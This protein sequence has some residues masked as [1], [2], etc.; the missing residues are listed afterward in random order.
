VLRSISLFAIA[1]FGCVGLVAASPPESQPQDVVSTER[2]VERIPQVRV[3]PAVPQTFSNEMGDLNILWPLLIPHYR[4]LHGSCGEFFPVAMQV[5]WQPNEWKQLRRILFRESRCDPTVLN[6]NPKTGDLSYGL[7]QI[8]MIRKLGPD[9]LTRC[10]LATYEDLWDPA[11]NLRCARIL[12]LT[13]G[14]GP[15]AY[16]KS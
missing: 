11:T 3:L 13:S 1:L 6:D 16:T 15:W 8:N 12:Y 9:R 10:N 2:F 5:G 7:T 4:E 14:W